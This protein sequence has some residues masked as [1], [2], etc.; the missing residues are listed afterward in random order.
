[1]R[2]TALFAPEKLIIGP[3][4]E[5]QIAIFHAVWN[6]SRGPTPLATIGMGKKNR[7][8]PPSGNGPG[9]RAFD[10][11]YRMPAGMET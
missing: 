11:E 4:Q 3:I 2:K 6:T 5:T 1:L 8:K 10:N 9:K 7:K